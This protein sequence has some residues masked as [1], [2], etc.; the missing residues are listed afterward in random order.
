MLIYDLHVNE[1]GVPI[2]QTLG[3]MKR[4][5]NMKLAFRRMDSNMLTLGK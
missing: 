4:R 5:E 3:V 2:F 1:N